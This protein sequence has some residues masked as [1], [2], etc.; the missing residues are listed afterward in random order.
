VR[1]SLAVLLFLGLTVP[2]RAQTAE[3]KSAIWPATTV[4]A[5][6]ATKHQDGTLRMEKVTLDFDNVVVTA[7][8][9]TWTA[10][11]SEREIELRG[12]VRI[13]SFVQV[14]GNRGPSLAATVDIQPNGI[15]RMTGVSLTFLNIVLTADEADVNS[16]NHAIELRGNVRVKA[17]AK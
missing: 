14:P 3:T 6:K 9:A 7:D 15:F 11:A 5:A 2:S 8:E 17:P 4:K 1:K 13:P 10:T 12:N 16:P